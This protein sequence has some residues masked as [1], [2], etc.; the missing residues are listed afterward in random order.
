MSRDGRRYVGPLDVRLRGFAVGHSLLER[1]TRPSVRSRPPVSST[2]VTDPAPPLLVDAH[3]HK[4]YITL[5]RPEALNAQNQAMRDALVG[6]VQRLDDDA[7]LLVGILYGAGGRA[8]SAG[9]D[10]KELSA[11]A[12][13]SRPVPEQHR[14]QWV[15]FEAVR[16]ASKPI[17]AAIDGYCLGGGLELAN[18]C[19]VRV[20]TERSRF[21]QP[22]PRTAGGRAGP[23]LHQL[24]RT[25]PIG[26]ALLM[27]LTS[28]PIDARRAYEIGLVQKLCPD[29][30]ALLAETDAIADQMIE[31]NPFAL[32]QIK[33]LVRWGAD[34]TAEQVEK[35]GLLVDEVRWQENSA[36]RRS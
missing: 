4:L 35:L 23:A 24:V 27:H 32:R 33:R 36:E 26:E 14:H 5:N 21:G 9:A 19:D 3:D 31:C 16:W 6:A 29:T 17:I 12:A 20:A 22:E 34:M 1:F 8:F 7:D 15:H 2:T 10:L 28:Q 30:E 18:Y 13:R 11:A 25:V